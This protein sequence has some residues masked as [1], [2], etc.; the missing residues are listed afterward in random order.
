MTAKPSE[1]S[2]TFVK[3]TWGE[4]LDLKVKNLI[5]LINIQKKNYVNIKQTTQLTYEEIGQK[6]GVGKLMAGDIIRE[7]KSDIVYV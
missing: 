7:K 4:R 2:F 6:F 3:S 5:M 1:F